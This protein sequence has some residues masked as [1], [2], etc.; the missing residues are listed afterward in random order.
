[1]LTRQKVQ[2][3]QPGAEPLTGIHPI[4]S[5]IYSNRGVE[6]V[7]DIDYAATGLQP[8]HSLKDIS[9]ATHRL[10]DALQQQQ[11]IM[12]IGDYDT[13][14][15][16]STAL[17]LSGL[18][19][20]GFE[21]VDYLVPNRFDFGYGLTPEIVTVAA[22][23]KPDLII[24]VDNGIA[25]LAGVQRANELGI[26]V[27]VTDHHLPGEQ[28]PEAVAIINPN[29]PG[30]EFPSKNLAGVGVMFYL[31]MALR[32]H[33]RSQGWFVRQGVAEP[34]L[35]HF[36][37]LVALGTVADVVPLDRNNRILVEQGLRRIRSGRALPGI[38]ALLRV[39]KRDYQ[40]L[41]A[42]DLGFAIGPRL[43]A[44]GRLDDI[45]LGIE[46]L[47]TQDPAMAE[48]YAAE[49]NTLNQERRLI[50]TEMQA[51]AIA[52]VDD[53]QL[54]AAEL[55]WGLAL[56]QSDWHQGVVG[57]VASRIKDRVHRP[58]IAF[59]DADERS[60]KGSARSIPGL[61]IRDALALVDS[62]HPGLIEKFGGHAMAAGL[63]LE[64]K[65]F[66]VFSE[67]FDQAVRSLLDIEQLS[68]VV[69]SDGELDHRE[70]NLDVARVLNNCGPW[71]QAFP[72]PVFDGVFHILHRKVLQERH[73][74]FTLI[75]EGGQRS[76]DAIVFN[77]APDEWPGDGESFHIAYSLEVNAY[78]GMER[79]Q[80]MIK[81]LGT[82]Q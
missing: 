70:L 47:L 65:H 62:E 50:E 57:L 76:V 31:L 41:R 73:L 28:L 53:L 29:Q 68:P 25:S 22:T 64:K 10:M 60:M 33:M 46:C 59:A 9:K 52:C 56:F 75:P 71:G 66:D 24:T 54:D 12:V 55:P 34:N 40:R 1:M 48:Q 67:A 36:L 39:A 5:R 79:A 38:L 26:D 51:Q 17:A 61:H 30:D 8:A 15:A 74:K 37:D 58:V 21:H 27:L 80:L 42:N 35:A 18:K 3:R 72:E 69:H 32:Q 43:N 81:A 45:S 82:V 16:T 23:K 78:Q 63:S 6:Q 13:D 19:S 44:A 77:V 2:R 11:S 4:L 7:A 14:G 20:L 49:L